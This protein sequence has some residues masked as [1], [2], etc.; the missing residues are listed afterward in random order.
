MP[1]AQPAKGNVENFHSL[2]C[3]GYICVSRTLT[4]KRRASQ[5]E[6]AQDLM[7]ERAWGWGL[8]VFR[9]GMETW[10]W[11]PEPVW[12]PG[13]C[14]P[15][16]RWGGRD[17]QPFGAWCPAHLA[18]PVSSSLSKRGRQHNSE[19]KGACCTSP[20]TQIRTPEPTWRWKER[21]VVFWPPWQHC[22]MCTPIH[23]LPYTHIVILCE[24][25]THIVI[26]NKK[27]QSNKSW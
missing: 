4:R 8:G 5:R 21:T 24:H 19:G 18:K 16:Q 3:S 7:V 1:K 9:T 10:G 11:T 27:L 12:Q 23:A 14:L 22:G 2:K 26:I 17:R 15:P 13:A 20:M 25:N 6:E